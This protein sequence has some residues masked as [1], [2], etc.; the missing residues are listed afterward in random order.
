MRPP[1]SS[2]APSSADT[3]SGV[4]PR[5]FQRWMTAMRLRAGHFLSSMFSAARS[6]LSRRSWSSASRMVKSRRRPTRSARSRRIRA[7]WDWKVPSHQPS[8][9][10]RLSSAATRFFI[11]LAALLVK[12]TAR[13]CPGLATRPVARIWASRVVSARVLPV[14]APAREQHRSVQGL[15][16]LELGF[17]ELGEIGLAARGLVRCRKFAHASP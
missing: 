13:I 4:R 17:V 6:C 7:A 16:G 1:A 2:P 5:S 9:E 8:T 15:H 10:S 14:P 12:V 3:L 11:S